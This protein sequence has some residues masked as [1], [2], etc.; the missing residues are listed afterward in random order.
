[1]NEKPSID[2]AIASAVS[3]LQDSSES[4]RLDAELLLARTL[5]VQRSYLFA[6]PNDEMDS[7]AAER[8]DNAV[9]QRADGMPMAYITGIKEFWSMPLIVSPVTLIPRPDTETLIEQ[10]LGRIPRNA[11]WEIADLGT[12]SGAIALALAKERPLCQLTATDRSEDA[13]AIAAQ[14]A[15][16]LGIPNIE[17]VAGNWTEPL[18]GRA[19]DVV[20]SNPPY[21]ASDD[22]HLMSLRFEPLDALD[23]GDDGLDAIRNLAS[24]AA[25]I[26][27]PSGS[28]LL[29]HGDAQEEPV[30]AILQDNGWQDIG[31]IRDI[32]GRPRVTAAIRP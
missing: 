10:A 20:V 19:F 30:A 26:L 17:F 6:H 25:T 3:Q 13:L 1:M 18:A 11:E 31:L 27:K 15:R 12:G 2:A 8:F 32:E 14:N 21:I 4:P 7:A 9:V 23:A 24:T 22:P 28:F 16:E 5:D 29:E